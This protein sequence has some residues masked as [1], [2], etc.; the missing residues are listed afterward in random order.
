M[1]NNKFCRWCKN[2]EMKEEIV[3]EKMPLTDDFIVKDNFFDEY[4]EDIHIYSCQSC[5]LI[6]NPNNF[7]F[8]RYYEDYNYSSGHSPFVQF[9]MQQLAMYTVEKYKYLFNSAPDTVLEI[10]S[11][12][13]V[14]LKE[15]QNLGLQ[16]LG[17]E[18]SNK[19][20]LQANKNKIFTLKEYFDETTIH[21]KL[22]GRKFSIILSSFTL[23]HIPDPKVFLNHIWEI[24]SD[25]SVI[26]FE[27]HDISKIITR[28][29]WCL[30]EH[31]HMI[32][33]DESFWR[34]NLIE[35]GFEFVEANPLP[36]NVVR[37]NSLI[38][39]GRKVQKDQALYEKPKVPALNIDKEK[40]RRVQNKIEKFLD[41]HENTV[42]GWGLGGRGVMTASL[43]RNSNRIRAFFDTNFEKSGYFTPQ[44]HIKI[45]SIK[46]LKNYQK[47]SV[48]VFSFG[49][50]DEICKELIDNGFTRENIFSLADFF[51]A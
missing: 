5:G 15:F 47:S 9:F 38:V 23:D 11:G 37:A 31:E 43:L 2:T 14:Q 24:S 22:K 20:Q 35:C 42:I 49:Y 3:F 45:E 30:F 10:G 1:S 50:F 19:L 21:Q 16:A 13:G 28:G 46:N 8:S 51:D 44:S 33:T 27:I 34:R 18:P 39:V 41:S 32:Y 36:E 4:I 17:I 29:E 6:Q 26:V 40:I 12:D 25:N 7:S 48:L